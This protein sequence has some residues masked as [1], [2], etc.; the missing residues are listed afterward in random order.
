MRERLS[1][2]GEMEMRNRL[3]YESQLRTNQEIEKLRRICYEEA[4]QLRSLQI[5]DL[6]LRHERDP[7]TVIRLLKQMHQ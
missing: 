3:R 1:L 5:E 6:F 7:N 4:N 2:C